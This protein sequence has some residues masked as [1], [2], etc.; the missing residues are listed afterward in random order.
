MGIMD[1]I[2]EEASSAVS[3][4]LNT[5]SQQQPAQQQTQMHQTQPKPRIPNYVV[6]QV[7]LKE[8]M[9]GSG[10]GNLS[11]LERVINNQASRGYRLHTISTA[12][13]SSGGFAGGDRI[14]ATLVFERL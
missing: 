6:L 1:R 3:A 4:T 7:T 12:S 9:I 14:Q 8:K 13:A 5:A 11:E 2:K 10:S